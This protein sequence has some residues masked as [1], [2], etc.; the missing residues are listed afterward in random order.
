MLAI[1]YHLKIVFKIVETVHLLA[2]LDDWYNDCKKRNCI[3]V[4]LES[5]N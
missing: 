3:L 5:R 1:V 4:F 2:M